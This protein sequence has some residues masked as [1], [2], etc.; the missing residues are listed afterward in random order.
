MP[1]KGGLLEGSSIGHH[2]WKAVLLQP[3]HKKKW[4]PMEGSPGGVYWRDPMEKCHGGVPWRGAWERGS[5]GGVPHWPPFLEGRF[6]AATAPKKEGSHGG[7]SCRGLLEG[8]HGEVPWRGAMEG[9]H[10]GIPWRG[11]MEGS[12]GG[13]PCRG[14]MQG[15]HGGVLWRGSL[16]GSSIG[17]H[18]WRAVLLQPQHKKTR[19]PME[20]SP[21]GVSW[22]GPME[23]SHGGVPWRGAWKRGS[24]GGAS[25]RPPFLEGRFTAATAQKKEG[26]HGGVSWRGLLEGSFSA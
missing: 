22:R 19:G 20:G 7:V 12:H 10:G 23:R 21:G 6:T 1:G 3:Q 25:Q 26:S 5:L 8:S 18:S 11:P 17:H 24:L 4:G 15:S 9:S 2:S 13:A 16:E 14:P